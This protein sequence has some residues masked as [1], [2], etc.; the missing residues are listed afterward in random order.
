M[1]EILSRGRCGLRAKTE[2]A[3]QQARDRFSSELDTNMCI[4][5]SAGAGKTRAIVDRVEALIRRPLP[6]TGEDPMDRLVVVTYGE[7]AAQE[8]KVRCR[9][10]LLGADFPPHTKNF[11]LARFNRIYFGTIHSFCLKLLRQYGSHLGLP[12]QIRLLSTQ[13]AVFFERFKQ[14]LDLSGLDWP[15]QR[16]RMALKYFSLEEVFKIA[17]SLQQDQVRYYLSAPD[18]MLPVP[19]ITP[20]LDY[21]VSERSENTIGR[22]QRQLQR[23]LRDV[24][25]DRP[26]LHLPKVDAG[27]RDFKADGKALLEPYQEWLAE[28]AVIMAAHIA[29][30]YRQHRL[31]HMRLTYDDMISETLRLT[32]NPKVLDTIRER[33]WIVILDEAQDTD[34]DMFQILI[35]ITRPT[36]AR[37]GSWPSEAGQPGPKDGHFSFVG[38]DQQCIYSSRA[39]IGKYL[40]Y[41]QA[42]E[43]GQ[44]GERLEFSV[45]M[46]CPEP[47]VSA[48]NRIFP[49]RI[50]QSRACFRQ[51]HS[52]P[53]H[54]HSS[55]AA[56]RLTLDLGI[57]EK[58]SDQDLFEAECLALGQWL[59]ESG[60]SGLGIDAWS[61]I[62]V[63]CP[64]VSWLASAGK[65]LVEAG[66][67]VAHKSSRQLAADRPLYTWPYALLHVMAYPYDRFELIG[68]LRDIFVISDSE[69]EVVHRSDP[70]GLSL[71]SGIHATGL[72]AEAL[73]FL[74]NGHY[75]LMGRRKG[76]T[77]R[78]IART[79]RELVESI[80]LE[81]RLCAV[82]EETDGLARFYKSVEEASASGWTL[83]DWLE[84]EKHKLEESSP[85]IA[86]MG[87]VDLI[88]CHKSKGLE[89]PVVILVGMWRKIYQK[90]PSY[91]S[92]HR[93]GDQ[94]RVLVNSESAGAD[95]KNRM[96]QLRE[97]ELQRLLYV[98]MTRSKQTLIISDP[99]IE[100][101][102]THFNGLIRWSEVR[103]KLDTKLPKYSA[104]SSQKPETRYLEQSSD[105]QR[106]AFLNWSNRIPERLLPHALAEDGDKLPEF[107]LGASERTEPGVGGVEYG[108][109]WHEWVELV[110][111]SKGRAACE[112]YRSESLLNLQRSGMHSAT[113]R[114][115]EA[116]VA[117]LWKSR[118]FELL[119]GEGE[120]FLAEMPFI[121]PVAQDQW[122]E[123]VIDLVVRS[124]NGDCW[125]IDWKTNRALT[126]ESEDE[127]Q[128]RL[129]SQYRPQLEAYA[130]ICAEQMKPRSIRCGL[131]LTTTAGYLNL[132]VA[133]GG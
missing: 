23:W 119:L 106:T 5:A 77:P 116:E 46:R 36:G 130:K 118:L 103:D 3:D 64:R 131:Y 60:L 98:A 78:P 89:W 91:P 42:F 109:V 19:D 94:I 105:E 88:S 61:E 99:D 37:F 13:D 80:R 2:L 49:E 56:I 129:S 82:D 26:F 113:L 117:M 21:A 10:R 58:M 101:K 110:P 22:I 43:A 9:E 97:E 108:S 123:G 38:D 121:W 95:W 92:V 35:E 107:S 11:M 50:Q 81:E 76:E 133:C 17:E 8:L 30:A 32:R 39:D 115:L 14:K 128:S 52:A 65:A 57:E 51:M 79:V 67:P 48:V 28:S 127:F 34:A 4:S 44:C 45:T 29:E 20:L 68:V 102:P 90:P 85:P 96:D 70:L 132:D 27:G 6:D 122:M 25:E 120:W 111:W 71:F 62:A 75:A 74:L 33:G 126:D 104:V 93:Q 7:M 55:S 112:V 72:C 87:G 125:V 69:I 54:D 84:F 73:K 16:C 124:K 86:T 15:P 1:A 31:D 40:D 59:S 100:G 66:I 114:R 12:G 18:T 41:V 53:F 63:L 47:V 24:R 83:M